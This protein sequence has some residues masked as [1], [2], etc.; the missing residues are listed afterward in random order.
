M[1]NLLKKEKSPYFKQHENNRVDW[2]A[3]NKETLLKAK[4]EKKI[5]IFKCRLCK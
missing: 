4:T 3:W 5:D 1:T 2:Y